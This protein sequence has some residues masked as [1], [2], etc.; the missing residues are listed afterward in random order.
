MQQTIETE[1]LTLRP[2]T[3][4]D[5]DALYDGL[6]EFEVTKNLIIPYP[7]TKQD[8]INFINNHLKNSTK[9]YSYAVV[10]KG[11]EH[12]IGGTSLDLDE[13]TQKYKGGIWLNKKYIGFGYG[14]EVFKA[15]AKFAFE[16]LK[17][18]ELNNG[19]FDWNEKSFRMQKKLGYKVVGKRKTF[20]PALNKEVTEILT[21]LTKQDFYNALNKL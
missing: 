7:Y 6:K 21:I 12:V 8:A 15:R 18:K 1:R 20:C 13:K 2:W 16:V 10:L 4:N 17:L 11:T 9:S 19:F 3:M 14:T 5:V